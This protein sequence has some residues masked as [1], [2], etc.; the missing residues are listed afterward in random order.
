MTVA[1]D[2]RRGRQHLDKD[3]CEAIVENRYVGDRIITIVFHLLNDVVSCCLFPH[4]GTKL[5]S[6]HSISPSMPK[7]LPPKKQTMN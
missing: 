2:G 5:F 3:K 1:S 6:Y 7:T 4:G